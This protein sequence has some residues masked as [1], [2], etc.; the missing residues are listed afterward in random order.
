MKRTHDLRIRSYI[1]A[2]VRHLAIVLLSLG[3]VSL[4]RA[5]DITGAGSTFVYP[6][7]SKWAAT[8]YARTGQQV[9][10][11]PTG[12]GNG[13]R[14]IRAASVTFGA[15]DMPL[16]SEDLRTVGLAQFPIV[17]GGVVACAFAIACR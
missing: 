10:Y 3:A 12:S 2:L 7:M 6:L 16:K 8:Y 5:G 13:I 9:N 1:H 15:T 4:A 17:I 14:Q 11:Q